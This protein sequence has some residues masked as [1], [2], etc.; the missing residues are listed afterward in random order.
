MTDKIMSNPTHDY[1]QQYFFVPRFYLLNL[2]SLLESP[3]KVGDHVSV[4]L[5]I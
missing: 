5:V 3:E 2:H 1:F 4:M